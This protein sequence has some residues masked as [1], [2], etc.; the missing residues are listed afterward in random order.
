VRAEAHV[1]LIDDDPADV[2]LIREA[3]REYPTV[4]TLESAGTLAE[5][6][7]LLDSERFDAVLL[8]LGLPDGEGLETLRKARLAAPELP[9]VVLTGNQDTDL[10]LKAVRSGAQ[11][12]L[13]KNAL[14]GILL[15]RTIRHAIERMRALRD[16][17]ESEERYRTLYERVDAGILEFD[18]A[19]KLT[20]ANPAL[21]QML[22]YQCLADVLALRPESRIFCDPEGFR[23]WFAAASRG[24][25]KG[26]KLRLRTASGRKIVALCSM[27]ELCSRDGALLG[28]QA[29][30]KDMTEVS[31]LSEQLSYEA[32]HDSL[33]DLLNRRM[34]EA[35]CRE[36]LESE[37]HLNWAF[38][39][40]D[41]DQFKIV[42][43]TCG[44]LAGDEL[45]KV[46]AAAI[47]ACVSSTGLLARL[48][49]DEFALLFRAQDEEQANAGAE[50]LLKAIEGVRFNWGSRAFETTASI[51]L[52]LTEAKHNDLEHLMSAADTAC[53]AAKDRG[54]GRIY[55]GQVGADTLDRKIREMHWVIRIK[56]A[57]SENRLLLYHQPVVPTRNPDGPCDH[58]EF[59]LR[60]VD[61]EGGIHTPAEF[62][63]AVERYN[64]ATTVD[65]WV[66]NSAL[67]WI[68]EHRDSLG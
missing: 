55:V 38:C 35:L 15:I 2:R 16:L 37:G 29:L 58:F 57:V 48:G 19:G 34:F 31:R 52:I 1:L 18:A 25:R 47:R 65:R 42:N 10:P 27:H 60:K 33:T 44:H 13:P 50:R 26:T 36:A 63:P 66:V 64:F 59:L 40:I 3:L 28:Y 12:Y 54:G 20:S 53:Y 8:D 56:A 68:K 67:T 45:L 4:L 62:L 7:Q 46:V 5:G 51:G 30:L 49:G 24:R 11:D 6:F 23:S 41:L 14:E 9:I 22:E 21:I 17:L 61:K 32:S 39:Y 43:D